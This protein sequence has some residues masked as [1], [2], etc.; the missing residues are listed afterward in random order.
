[1]HPQV[2]SVESE[3]LNGREKMPRCTHTIV[4]STLSWD[5]PLI[6][7]PPQ[8]KHRYQS[9]STTAAAVWT[10]VVRST[11]LFDLPVM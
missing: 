4:D 6:I 8:G 5:V 7:P 2:V 11:R 3:S 10:V 1:M 9:L